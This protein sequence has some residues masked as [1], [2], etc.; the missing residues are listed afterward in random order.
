[1]S[2]AIRRALAD[3]VVKERQRAGLR[4]VWQQPGYRM[5][6]IRERQSRSYDPDNSRAALALAMTAEARLKASASHRR[7]REKGAEHQRRM[8][9]EMA[10]MAGVGPEMR[11]VELMRLWLSHGLRQ[12]YLAEWLGVHPR[13]LSSWVRGKRVPRG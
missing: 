7:T 8:V 13:S 10:A 11:D 3:P 6:Q 2:D 5:H 12:T 1:M 4:A 9:R